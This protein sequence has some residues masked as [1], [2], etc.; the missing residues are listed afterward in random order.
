MDKDK[1]RL[2]QF[3]IC[4]EFTTARQDSY[5]AENILGN[6]YVPAFPY[7]FEKLYAVTC[8][9]K[10]QKF[11]K[12]VIEYE[13]EYGAKARSAHMDI[14]P[15]TNSVLFRWHKHRFPANFVIEKPTHLTVRVILDWEVLWESYILI[16]KTHAGST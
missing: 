14:E 15:I 1:I 16:E 11:H 13:T 3:F 8:W 2:L 4:K 6:L 7:H 5:L 9:R 10:D 12:E